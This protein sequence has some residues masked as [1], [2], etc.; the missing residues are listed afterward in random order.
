MPD[1][2]DWRGQNRVFESLAASATAGFNLTN[3]GEPERL[4]G[5]QVTANLFPTLGVAPAMGRN[6]RDEEDRPG[7][8]PVAILSHGLWQ[9]RFGCEAN[10]VG[11]S[12]TLNGLSYTVVGVMPAGFQFPSSAEIWAPLASDPA[13][14]HRRS[15]F[16]L[17]VGR[18]K[19]GITIQ[20]AQADMSAVAQRLKRQYPESNKNWD[21][22]VVSLHEQAVGRVRTALLVL[23]GAVGCVLLVACAN[24]A[25][26]LL[27]RSAARQQEIA[28]RAALGASRVRTI[29][30]LLTE[31]VL[32]AA[33]G[34]AA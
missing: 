11:R 26:L 5:A 24:V 22:A 20:Q 25:N 15:N 9:R 10:I 29:R 31:S 23:L 13:R 6:F 21:V 16:L 19:P 12:L 17:V 2:A 1:Y 14:M 28:V 34:G 3:R 18:L 33:L 32:L 27:A 8:G 4:T 30:Q 7:A